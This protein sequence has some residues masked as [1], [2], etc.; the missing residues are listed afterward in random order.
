MAP[1]FMER[2]QKQSAGYRNVFGDPHFDPPPYPPTRGRS[3][4]TMSSALG[5]LQRE[6]GKPLPSP[7]PQYHQ[8]TQA[9]AAAFH[10]PAL[11]QDSL[12]LVT[13]ANGW[14]GMH[15]VDQ[16]LEHG[17]RVRGTVRDAEKA[18][19]TSR[20]FEDKHGPGKY[21]TAVIPDMVPRGAFDIAAKGCAGIIHV[22]SVMTFSPDPNE[23]IAPSIAGALNALEAAAREP[24]IRRFIYCSASAA[25]VAQGTGVRSEV[26]NESWNMAAFRAAWEPPPYEI[27]R[28]WAVFA[29]SKMQTEQAVWRWYHAKRPL[30]TLTTG[31]CWLPFCGSPS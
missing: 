23:V 1:R 9:G 13:G 29:S 24:S 18:V 27:D 19:W 28:A 8:V 16:L 2:M 30:F 12:I 14:Q 22:A 26:T 15:V 7:P 6:Q 20:Y 10:Q 3:L 31:K 21:T 11:P 5:S 25:A 17:Y 4:S